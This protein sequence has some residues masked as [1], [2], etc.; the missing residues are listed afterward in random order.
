MLESTVGAHGRIT[1]P[2]AL[3]SALGLQADDRVRYVVQGNSVQI[4]L[5]RTIHRLF[6][7]LSYD[8]PHVT[9][10]DMDAAIAGGALRQ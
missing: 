6:G 10:D 7:A 4:V 2:R 5:V 1:L 9:L 3:R 8:G